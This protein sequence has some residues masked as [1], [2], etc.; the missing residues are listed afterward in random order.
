MEKNKAL[1]RLTGK[2]LQDL[3][4]KGFRYMLIKEYSPGRHLDHI[5][6]NHFVLLPVRDL[7]LD[8]ADK[9]IYAPIDSEILL[10]WANSTDHGFKAF[11]ESAV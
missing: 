8:P 5:Q 1:T 7:P 2:V 4:D 6:L 9:E 10:D 3:I 11:I